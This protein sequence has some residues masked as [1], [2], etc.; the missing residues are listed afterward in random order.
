[1]NI[2]FLTDARPRQSVK[3]V[4]VPVPTC[5]V[6]S[7]SKVR[8]SCMQTRKCDSLECVVEDMKMV[9]QYSMWVVKPIKAWINPKKKPGEGGRM[10]HHRGDG[11]F[12]VDGEVLD[13]KDRMT[14]WQEFQD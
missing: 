11:T 1:M 10:F 12:V 9:A 8:D 14:K 4:F 13:L 5:E 6:A 2:I 7:L 3:D